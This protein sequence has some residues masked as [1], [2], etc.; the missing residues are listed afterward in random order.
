MRRFFRLPYLAII[1]V[2][3]ILYS[4]IILSGKA[5]FWGVPSLQFIPWKVYALESLKQGILP[6]WN[7]LNG[8]G[9]PLIANYQ[10]A[11]FYPPN[12]ILFFLY[13]LGGI[14]WM[15]W[16]HTIL[17]AMHLAWAGLGMVK[18]TKK[19]GLSETGQ[20]ISGLSFALS[21]YLVAR[22]GFFSLV[23][24]ASW[25]PWIVYS[26]CNFA[27]PFKV[28]EVMNTELQIDGEKY[29]TKLVKGIFSQINQFLPLTVCI[30]LQLLAGHAQVTYFSLLFLTAWIIF[31][32][33]IQNGFKGIAK[34]VSLEFFAVL[35]G[36]LL[37][38]IQLLPTAELLAQSQRSGF[39]DYETAMT[40]SFWPW[41][42][43]TLIA[44]NLFGNPGTGDYWGYGNYWEDAVYIGLL[45]IILAVLPLFKALKRKTSAWQFR[46]LVIFLWITAAI[47]FILALGKNTPIFPFLYQYIPTFDMFQAPTRFTLIAEFSMA[48]LAGIG[49]EIIA[50]PVG[51]GLYWLRLS[52]MGGVAVTVGAFLAWRFLGDIKSTFIYATA[53]AGFWSL[54]AGLIILEIPNG[55]KSKKTWNY[56]VIVVVMMDLLVAG[57][58]LNPGIEST[59][60]NTPIQQATRLK[61]NPLKHRLYLSLSEEYVL[62]YERFLSFKSF[63][64][65][66]SWNNLR[67]VM[68][69]NLNLIDG[70]ASANNFDPLLSSRYDRWM[71]TID[72]LDG[73]DVIPWL[74]IMDVGL[75]E[76]IDLSN[77]LGVKFEPLN[78]AKRYWWFPCAIHVMNGE[79]AWKNLEHSMLTKDLDKVIW[80][81][82]SSSE[83]Q[84]CDPVD[85]EYEVLIETSQKIVFQIQNS[86]GGYFVLSDA[87]FP[88]WNATLDGNPV[89]IVPANYLFRGIKLEVGSHLLE[90][91]YRPRSFLIGSLIS[92]ISLVLLILLMSLKSI[93]KRHDKS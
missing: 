39:V 4:P 81:D 57:W 32:G 87:W 69:A 72:K 12:W 91:E 68:L 83:D 45:P 36:L 31:S 16:G 80:E 33:F 82:G 37:S 65:N 63:S 28:N 24:A 53:M 11:F 93:F 46:S 75:V 70:I 52:I 35:S 90:F 40:Y 34:A 22:T 26:A 14:S 41:R 71:K 8:M 62:K 78:G 59:F 19:L 6:L 92:G 56:L 60:Y 30:T 84:N 51:K 38:A 43:M 61:D 86:Q 21:G 74:Q 47:S 49:L 42:F 67:N 50:K 44:P 29:W 48:L 15:A 13:F 76:K 25:L 54:L 66:E 23:W 55:E 10:L 77:D 58:K 7:P 79:E 2:P 17:A 73:D 27:H 18:L 1:L 89:A 85:I 64:L 88:G 3:F 5:L 9:S 20:V